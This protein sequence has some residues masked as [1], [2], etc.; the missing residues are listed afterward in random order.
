[1]LDHY[2]INLINKMV[3][4]IVST[5]NTETSIAEMVAKIISEPSLMFNTSSLAAK[6]LG[7]KYNSN[8]TIIDLTK[9]INHVKCDDN[10]FDIREELCSTM[11]FSLMTSYKL[12]YDLLLWGKYGNIDTEHLDAFIDLFKFMEDQKDD[13]YSNYKEYI[14][15]AL[16]YAK[17]NLYKLI[18]ENSD[19]AD[20]I[21]NYER[22]NKW[23]TVGN[24]IWLFICK[25]GII[26]NNGELVKQLVKQ[27]E[28]SNE[29]VVQLFSKAVSELT[30]E[31][32]IADDVLFDILAAKRVIVEELYEDSGI[33]IMDDEEQI[34]YL[35]EAIRHLT[36]ARNK[37]KNYRG[38]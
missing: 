8:D 13:Y 12:K 2:D 29:Y 15:I 5:G 25:L 27:D 16:K 19:L 33:S 28:I 3:D 4:D 18:S 1:M 20:K 24:S 7:V 11:V 17:Y 36:E 22:Y 32:A 34:D 35:D 21:I 26:N 31:L 38:Y 10:I 30:G 37:I 23:A 14:D 9:R 6:L